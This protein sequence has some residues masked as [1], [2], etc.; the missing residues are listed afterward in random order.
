MFGTTN[1]PSATLTVLGA[2]PQI[3]SGPT[4]LAVKAGTIVTLTVTATGPELR[5]QWFLNTMKLAATNNRVIFS[6]N[7][8][9]AGSYTA[10]V[11]NPWG[12]NS[13]TANIA[14]RI[15]ASSLRWTKSGTTQ[16]L[17]VSGTSDDVWKIQTSTNLADWT[18]VWTNVV[19]DAGGNATCI[20]TNNRDR[21]FFRAAQ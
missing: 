1:S 19:I 21:Q 20:V 5:Y 4:N 16:M 7:S 2:A 8:G 12:S 14:L 11:Y 17:T 3:I 6:M 13:I 15:P 10:K 9:L 18:T